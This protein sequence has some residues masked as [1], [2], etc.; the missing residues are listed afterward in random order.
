MAQIQERELENLTLAKQKSDKEPSH[1]SIAIEKWMDRLKLCVYQTT[2]E[3][4]WNV[5]IV[6]KK[7]LKVAQSR[8]HVR[9]RRWNECGG[10]QRAIPRSD[11]VLTAAKLAGCALCAANT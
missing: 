5:V 6:M 8:M 9:H 7:L 11:P 1:A 2:V 3:Q 4:G 10:C